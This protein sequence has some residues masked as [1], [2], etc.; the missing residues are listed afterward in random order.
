MQLTISQDELLNYVAS[1]INTL[2]PD[3]SEV[4]LR[5]L[6]QGHANALLRLEHCFIKLCVRKYC[7]G[8][9]TYFNHLYSD[10]YLMYLW[11]LSNS[12][13]K[14][15]A[16][17]NVLNKVYLLNKCLHGFDC[18]FDTALPDI[19]IV[20]HGVG[21][22]LGKARYSDYLTVYQGCTVG[23]THGI[24]PRLGRGVGL[25]AGVAIIGNSNIGDFV[26][27]GAGC[28]LVN[29][30]IASGSSVFREPTGALVS[31]QATPAAIARQYFR[32]D[33]L[34]DKETR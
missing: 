18:A 3:G 8:T 26:S 11:F 30:E 31:R 33:F 5:D 6:T 23:Q 27:V 17:P 10:Q 29:S 19:F 9:N 20:I 32:E 16:N 4:A 21:T 14:V 13:W 2:F 25:G 22:V 34:F 1:Q 15:G 24:Y 28:S 12:L 7:V